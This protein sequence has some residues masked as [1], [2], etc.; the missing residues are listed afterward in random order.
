M[1][2]IWTEACE[3]TIGK[4]KTTYKDWMS[5]NTLEKIEKGEKVES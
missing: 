4:K 1:K 2:N 5:L 3:E